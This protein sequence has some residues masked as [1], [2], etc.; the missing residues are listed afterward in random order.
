[1]SSKRSS[2]DKNKPLSS[3]VYEIPLSDEELIIIGRIAVMWGHIDQQID[4]ILSRLLGLKLV[5]LADI[6]SG[7][8]IGAKIEFL[9]KGAYR[10]KNKENEKAV[11]DCYTKV[12]A[13]VAER[14]IVFHGSWGREAYN[15]K[16]PFVPCALHRTK[17]SYF[18]ADRLWKFHELVNE[19]SIA[20]DAACTMVC[21]GVPVSDA[22]NR[23]TYFGREGKAPPAV[24][25]QA[26]YIR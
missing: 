12:K 26:R 8:M 1:M 11:K 17:G 9:K 24:V 2:S 10:A 22:R 18:Y 15:K 20:T 6:L 3:P 7:K 19:A 14:N 4:L 5:E 16:R 23:S 13:C 21:F 25:P